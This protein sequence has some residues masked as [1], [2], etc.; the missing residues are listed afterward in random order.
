MSGSSDRGPSDGAVSPAARPASSKRIYHRVQYGL[1]AALACG[2]AA[3]VGH[4]LQQLR[5][6]VSPLVW[7]GAQ[8]ISALLCLTIAANVLVR[9][10]GT[11]DRMS[12]LLGVT[13]AVSGVVHLGSIAEFY[14]DSLLLGGQSRVLLSWMVGQTLLGF[15]FLCGFAMDE[16][17]PWPRE[18]RRV[19]L[20]GIAVILA[21]TASLTI[22]YSIVPYA[23]PLHF[24]NTVPRAL[25]LLPAA[26]FMAAA[27]VLQRYKNR[28]RF[29][30]DH[31]LVWAAGMNAA[32][33]V[34]ASQSARLFDVPEAASQ[35]LTMSTC[36]ILLGATLF[37]NARLFDQV[38][39]L[40]TSDS[41]TGLAN[42]RTLVDLLQSELER[43]G[44]T[45]R[46]FALLLMDLDGLKA[47]NDQYGHLTG[48]RALCRV[49]AILKE[50]SR[51]ID[52]AA[53]YG[54]DE[55]ALVLPE[56]RELSAQQV[57]ERIHLRLRGDV[58]APPLSMSVGI[59]TFPHAGTTAR[60]LLET[61]D[62][63]LYQM[64][65]RSKKGRPR[66]SKH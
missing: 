12:L 6:N 24:G 20:A 43:S 58:E 16:H 64:K 28:E 45:N 23:P 30:F 32:S 50:N 52:T 14:R 3:V 65:I 8:I 27:V 17:L 29:A 38:K 59:A 31:V 21:A 40:A 56:T 11:A 54:G 42:Y 47:I 66:K 34:I 4:F 33:H 19:V 1:L 9:Y 63:A 51:A 53:R 13:F 26:L 55:F 5:V 44:R 46:S 39:T 25:D 37:D 60:A 57:V 36:L 41:L 2:G 62:R 15:V 61:A 10:H 48:S 35:I 22:L 18:P 49:A 7:A